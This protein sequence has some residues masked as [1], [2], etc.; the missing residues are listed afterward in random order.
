MADVLLVYPRQGINV[1]HV[2][3]W[4]PLSFLSAA[5]PLL[6][7]GYSVK[8]L[9]ARLDDN[10]EN[11][12]KDEIKKKPLVVG[13]TAMA[14]PQL[15]WA[16]RTAEIVRETDASIPVLWGGVLVNLISTTA[17]KDS[18][19]DILVMGDAEEA[20]GRLGQPDRRRGVPTRSPPTGWYGA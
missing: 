10:W 15:H 13:L 4:L 17:I 6:Q 7:A 8:I 16:L 12:L 5:G 11:T 1:K 2:S 3:V 18:R 20:L 9:D 14:G 19:V